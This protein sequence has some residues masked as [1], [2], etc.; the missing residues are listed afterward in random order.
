MSDRRRR[1]PQ[2]ENRKI[3]AFK[4]AKGKSKTIGKPI[5]VWAVLVLVLIVIIYGLPWLEDTLKRTYILE[6]ETMEISENVSLYIARDEVVYGAP[7]TGSLVYIAEE[8]ELM[9]KGTQ[10]LNMTAIE[11]S[12][13]EEPSTKY[14]DITKNLGD[15]MQIMEDFTSLRKGV[16][17]YF[18]DGNEGLI[19]LDSIYN[20]TEAQMNDIDS[21]PE[22][23]ERNHAEHGE[24]IFKIVDNSSWAMA[25][26]V[27]LKSEGLYVEG[28]R[29]TVSFDEDEVRATVSQ[30]KKEGDKIKVVLITNRYHEKF[31]EDRNVEAKITIEEE[32]GLIAKKDS[33][34]QRFGEKNGVYVITSLG[35]ERFVRVEILLENDDEV[36]LREGFFYDEDGKIIDSVWPYQEILRNP[37]EEELKYELYL[38]PDERKKEEKDSN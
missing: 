38:P 28:D 20:M 21:N 18:V 34:T 23:L 30:V 24:P 6:N 5:I 29:V 25:F 4:K 36:L 14:D 35:E 33:I 1:R 32:Y 15:N 22:D 13:T 16:V 19:N 9:K 17:S 37:Y 2:G 31:A 27:D 7:Y 11:S 3:I 10:I 12:T 8:G 26:W